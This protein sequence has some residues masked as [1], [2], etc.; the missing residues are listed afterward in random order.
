MKAFVRAWLTVSVLTVLI[1]TGDLAAQPAATATGLRL[2]FLPQ[3]AIQKHRSAGMLQGPSLWE[4][5]D[6]GVVDRTVFAWQR[7]AIQ[8]AALVAKTVRL[9][10]EPEATALGGRGRFELV[11]VR[12]P[13]GRAAWTEV[14][15]RRSAPA[16]DD[17]LVL[18][19]GGERNTVMQVLET[20]LLARG[21]GSRLEEVPLVPIA[22][23]P[24]GGVPVITAP[25][26]QALGAEANARFHEVGGVALLVLRSPVA[27]IRNGDLTPNGLADTARFSG[28]D[29]R[30]ADRILLRVPGARVGSDLPG[31]ILGWKDRTLQNDPEGDL[32]RRSSLPLPLVR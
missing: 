18:E 28:G 5:V 6:G 2:A 29:W 14:E 23:I 25:A 20:L 13:A 8:R 19:I 9:V 7:G 10:P 17:I 32:P 22:L 1:G 4:A 30:D 21:P 11:A 15:V 31:L 26:G 3:W 24:S 27:T 16:A 12:P